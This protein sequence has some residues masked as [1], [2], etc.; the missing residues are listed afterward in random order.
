[1][2]AVDK[3]IKSAIDSVKKTQESND[4]TDAVSCWS[5]STAWAL[6]AKLITDDPEQNYWCVDST[7]AS[8]VVNSHASSTNCPK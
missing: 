5:S 3:D 2:Y 4:T 6:S 7:G 1:M 8:Q